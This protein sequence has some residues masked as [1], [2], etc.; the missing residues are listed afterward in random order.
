MTKLPGL[1]DAVTNY[2]VVKFNYE[3]D[4]VTAEAHLLGENKAGDKILS[5]WVLSS[6][7]GSKGWKRYSLPRMRDVE[8]TEVTY[9]RT[10][11]GYD[12]Q[13]ATMARIDTAAA[14]KP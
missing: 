7:K 11:D 3:G 12:A 14:P 13:D 10:R 5:A 4:L 6:S 8:M 1:R 2:K 9:E